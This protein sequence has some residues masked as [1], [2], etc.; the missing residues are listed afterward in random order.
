MSPSSSD[1]P[2]ASK[3]AQ[4]CISEEK[5]AVIKMFMK[6]TSPHMRHVA[7]TQRLDLDW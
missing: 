1:A 7:E 5:K 4:L 3:R 2:H 6:G